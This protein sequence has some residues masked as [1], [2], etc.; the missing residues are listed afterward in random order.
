M[1]RAISSKRESVGPVETV[2]FV[3]DIRWS[4]SRLSCLFFMVFSTKS[5]RQRLYS[6]ALSVS[7]SNVNLSW[8]IWFNALVS[9]VRRNWF[10]AWS[11]PMGFF[12]RRRLFLE[13]LRFDSH[14]ASF[15]ACSIVSFSSSADDS[16]SIR[17]SLFWFL[18]S[19]DWRCNVYVRSLVCFS[20]HSVSN[21][22][23]YS[24]LLL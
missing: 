2:L 24:Q 20:L 11:V 6:S 19:W 23:G 16:S 14:R 15:L 4:S 13:D 1:E 3:P 7:C 9:S 18:E 8:S 10:S 5:W 17:P 21:I 12:W 22:T